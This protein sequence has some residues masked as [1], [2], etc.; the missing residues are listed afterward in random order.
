MEIDDQNI[1]R[2]VN[3]DVTSG[4]WMLEIVIDLIL[5]KKQRWYNIIT[6]NIIKQD[7]K[8]DS[9]GSKLKI[10]KTR[11]Y[12]K[13]SLINYQTLATTFHRH[14][15]LVIL[16]KY[17]MSTCSQ[18]GLMKITEYII[19]DA[20]FHELSTLPRVYLLGWKTRVELEINFHCIFE[21]W[22]HKKII[23]IKVSFI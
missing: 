23:F 3:L 4:T 16:I 14:T 22:N 21:K 11:V 1:Q 20:R 2:F 8:W 5:F 7:S 12:H 18:N 10:A 19:I 6:K 9:D 17:Q 15:Y 13:N